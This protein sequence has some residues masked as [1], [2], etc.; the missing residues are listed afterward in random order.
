M[1]TLGLYW[2]YLGFILNYT[3][4][5]VVQIGA[6]CNIMLPK[7]DVLFITAK[8]SYKLLTTL[9]ILSFVGVI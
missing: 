8:H 1:D 4:V 9:I 6:A 5:T 2:S 3:I 7:K